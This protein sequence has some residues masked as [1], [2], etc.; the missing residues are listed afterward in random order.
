MKRI[1][2]FSCLLMVAGCTDESPREVQALVDAHGCGSCHLMP[3]IPGATGRTGPPLKEY[4]RQ[5]YVAGILPNTRETL[6]RFIE[7]PQAIDPRS[8]MPDVGVTAREA[9]LL[10]DY[11]RSEP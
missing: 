5:V 10:A 11:L 6:A 8:A 9:T 3:G 2:A 7:D 4:Y 1:I